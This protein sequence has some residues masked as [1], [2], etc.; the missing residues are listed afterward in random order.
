[1]NDQFVSRIWP[2]A[3]SVSQRTGLDPRL[4][5]AQ[6]ALETGWGKSAPNNN[7]F[8][9]KSHGQGGGSVQA[10][11]E[12]ENGQMVSRNANFRAYDDIGQSA[13]DYATFLETNPRYKP[14]LE[15]VGLDN[16]I[17]AL[18]TSGYATDPLYGDK[19][20][21]IAMGID[22][23]NRALSAPA[24]AE[25]EKL[26]LSDFFGEPQQ[27]AP[28]VTRGQPMQD[29]LLSQFGKGP[30]GNDQKDLPFYQRDKFKDIAGGIAVAANS[31]RHRPDPNLDARI[32]QAQQGRQ[33]KQQTNKTVQWLQARGRDDLAEAVATGALDPRQAVGLIYQ[34]QSSKVGAQEILE[35]GTI[36]QST[37]NGPKVF[38]PDGSE[39]TGQ[40]AA[41][42]IRASREYSVSN[43]R[44]IYNARKTGTNT[45]E[46]ET[47]GEAAR[48]VAEGGQAPTV[49]REYLE[50][51]EVVG[52]TIRN[53]GS[54]IKAID[55]GAQSG[56]VY[57]MLPNVT[58]ASAELQNAK[59]RLGL[60][61]I[62]SVTF[63][64]LSENEMRVAMDTA[65]PQD[66]APPELR[67]W[68]VEKQ[69]AQQKMHAALTEAAYHF[70]SGGTM[71]DYIK[72][73]NSQ[74]GAAPTNGDLSDE[75]L[76][77]KYGG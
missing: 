66:L 13:N 62:G 30:S 37:A 49:A 50:Q 16:Q 9:I 14:L 73:Y 53:M 2:H 45:A 34:D 36:I 26:G 32:A 69:A 25:A 52:S 46:I 23:N 39:L 18:A 40:A 74:P 11:K 41:D 35:D 5:A 12:F 31:L 58:K 6:A 28:Q 64:A 67:E 42:A 22:P 59:N 19:V 55:E 77:R 72:K 65:V 4:V 38:G 8:G 33:Q 1:M 71:A 76:K 57:N 27:P 3:L 43:Q 48:V 44:E 68:L 47:G 60:D 20:R 7:Y 75:E 70:A 63:G 51:A 29:G 61:V 56:V 24:R 54:A 17:A 15:S 10:T 21:S